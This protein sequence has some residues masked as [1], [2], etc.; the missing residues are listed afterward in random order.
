MQLLGTVEEN[1]TSHT[2]QQQEQAKEARKLHHIIGAPMV[3]NFKHIIKS[4]QIWNCPITVEDIEVAEKICGKDTSHL[5]GK[6]TQRYPT[7][8]TTAAITVPKE[9]REQ[10]KT[11]LHTLTSCAL[12][13]FDL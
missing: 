5:K 7:T 9:L 4:N 10:N 11:S 2:K 6:T 8:T 3:N 12:T 1:A 13:K